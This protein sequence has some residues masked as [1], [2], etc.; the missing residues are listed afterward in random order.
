FTVTTSGGRPLRSTT[1]APGT[2]RPAS[3]SGGA[4]VSGGVA[5]GV[6]LR[7][8]AGPSGISSVTVMVGL[9]MRRAPGFGGG[10]EGTAAAGAADSRAGVARGPGSPPPSPAPGA[11]AGGTSRRA[12]TNDQNDDSSRYASTSVTPASSSSTE[13]RPKIRRL[14]P[15]RDDDAL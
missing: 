14:S 11:S 5:A 1:L 8:R 3:G 13:G 10:G 9:P 2:L 15:P 6:A 4:E 7:P 12:P